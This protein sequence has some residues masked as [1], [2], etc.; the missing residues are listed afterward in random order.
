[1]SIN[2]EIDV[3]LAALDKAI[4]AFRMT[5]RETAVRMLIYLQSRFVDCVQTK[6]E[7]AKSR[8]ISKGAK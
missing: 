5:D 3:E 2:P 7:A 8:I 6:E 1:M 4:D